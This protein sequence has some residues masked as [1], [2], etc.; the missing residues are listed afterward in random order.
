MC[1]SILKYIYYIHT[2]IYVCTI[3]VSGI[4]GGKEKMWLTYAHC[5][6]TES[7]SSAK[8]MVTLR[9]YLSSLGLFS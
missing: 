3:C 8:T 9:H 4:L 1:T 7:R 5:V 6:G 2:H